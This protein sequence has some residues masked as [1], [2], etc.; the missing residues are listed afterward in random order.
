MAIFRISVWD[1]DF[2]SDDDQMTM[3]QTITVS[4]VRQYNKWH[5]QNSSCRSYILLD[6]GV[7]PIACTLI[8]TA[9]YGRNLQQSFP[10]MKFTGQYVIGNSSYSVTKSSRFQITRNP[11]WNHQVTLGSHPW[12]ELKVRVYDV[13]FLG[14]DDALSSLKSYPVHQGTQ[15]NGFTL[16]GYTG[17]V[18]FDY[19]CL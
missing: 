6:Y 2:R 1:K 11:N 8:V 5:C 13:N 9:R 16:N 17:F 4:H 19:V 7:A 14:S 10:Y 15:R 3:S 18:V 12:T